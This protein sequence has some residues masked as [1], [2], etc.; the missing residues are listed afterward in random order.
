MGFL[1]VFKKVGGVLRGFG[2]VSAVVPL[3]VSAVER[4]LPEA[5]GPEKLEQVV[6][7]AKLLFPEVFK[8]L[9][10]DALAE[11]LVGIEQVVSGSV[12]IY[13]AIGVFRH[14]N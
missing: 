14:K 2:G 12:K 4:F 5:K 10:E 8:D 3:I 11:L 6:T 13:H 9:D 7:I 1:S